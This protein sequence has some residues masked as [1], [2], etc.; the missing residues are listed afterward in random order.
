MNVK[1]FSQFRNHRSDRWLAG[2]HMLGRTMAAWPTKRMRN[3]L[4]YRLAFPARSRIQIQT[5]ASPGPLAMRCPFCA[6]ILTACFLTQSIHVGHDLPQDNR[7]WRSGRVWWWPYALLGLPLSSCPACWVS[8]PQWRALAGRSV[9]SI[10]SQCT[11]RPLD[12][13]S[14]DINPESA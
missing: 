9:D 6:A 14:G 11:S 2:Y 3:E 8:V 5:N 13:W 4:T 1:S 10:D 12:R 7:A